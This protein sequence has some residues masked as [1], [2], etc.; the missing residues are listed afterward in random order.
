M[1]EI[2]FHIIHDK[3]TK[4]KIKILKILNEKQEFISSDTIAQMLDCS[5]KTILNDINQLKEELPKDWVITSVKSKG[6]KILNQ[7]RNKLVLPI[8]SYLKKSVIYQVILGIY[9][10]KHYTLEKWSQILYINKQPL[11]IILSKFNNF[12]KCGGVRINL[13][14]LKLEGDE[15]N[16]RH[17]YIGFFY[18]TQKYIDNIQIP[19]TL[20]KEVLQDLSEKKLE[21]D[22]NLLNILIAVYITRQ[23]SKKYIDQIINLQEILKQIDLKY[24][25]NSVSIIENYYRH[26]FLEIEK[27]VFALSLFMISKENPF[28]LSSHKIM[29]NIRCQTLYQTIIEENHLDGKSNENLFLD[30]KHRFNK[31][32]VLSYFSLPIQFFVN[33]DKVFDDRFQLFQKNYELVSLWNETYNQKKFTMHEL[34]YLT[35]S[36]LLHFN[37]KP[38]K[39]NGLF[40]FS[41]TVV[42][43][44]M[45]YLKML[46]NLGEWIYLDKKSISNKKYDFIITNYPLTNIALPTFYISNDCEKGDIN[47]IKKEVKQYIDLITGV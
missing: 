2:I 37:F 23:F 4:R 17:F 15:I 43:E 22:F 20:I 34:R 11:K 10:N 47:K 41:G 44:N 29:K 13:N 35:S 28:Q 31:I 9:Q 6:H 40:L 3:D 39:L 18:M 12:I 7:S 1:N 46:N 38:F 16:I 42:E 19:H 8:A 21:V 26:K 30:F 14:Y 36:I 24:F 25:Y 45:V 33:T 5:N 32:E 27:R